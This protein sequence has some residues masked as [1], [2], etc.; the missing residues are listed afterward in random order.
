MTWRDTLRWL[1]K[2][3]PVDAHVTVRRVRLV[4]NHGSTKYDGCGN[5][6]VYI[7]S[8][9]DASQQIHTLLHE[10]AHVRAISEAY[11]HHGRWSEIYGDIYDSF[12]KA[13]NNAHGN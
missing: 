5:Y 6:T 10:F 7:S 3:Y 13:A 8:N 1:R 11:D 2:N 12:M 9:Q 4:K